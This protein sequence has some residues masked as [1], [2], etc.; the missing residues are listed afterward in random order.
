MRSQCWVCNEWSHGLVE[1]VTEYG[2][3]SD[4]RYLAHEHEVA[5]LKQRIKEARAQIKA[6]KAEAMRKYGQRYAH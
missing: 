3:A 6:E 4:M 1:V 5:G 2:R